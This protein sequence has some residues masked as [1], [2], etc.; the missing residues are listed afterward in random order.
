MRSQ[1]EKRWGRGWGVRF[2]PRTVVHV[3][4]D[5]FFAQVEALDNP[6]YR[7]RPLIVGGPRDSPR[8]VVATCS[9]E[10]RRFGV[11]SAM[12]I[13][14]AVRLCPH[15]VFVTPRM[16]R[17]REVSRHI[18]EILSSIS[19]LMEPLSVDE[20]FLD[21]TG[22]EP[23]YRDAL[24]LGAEIKRRIREGTGLTA[25]VGIAPNKFIA[26]LASDSGKPDG[27][28][29]IPEHEVDRFLLPL[30]VD[31]LWGVG[32]RT[33][34]RLREAGMHTV[35]DVRARPLS[36]LIAVLG[37]RVGRHVWNFAFGR[38]ERPVQARTEAK[39][40]G[41]ET[42][43][44]VDVPDGPQLRAH[45][46]RLVASVGE[47][48]RRRGLYPRTVTVKVRFPDFTTR[49]RSRTVAEG[50]RDDETLFRHA[51]ALL[52]GFRLRRP[53]RL[54]GVSVSQ[55]QGHVQVPLFPLEDD[56]TDPEPSP[57]Y[58]SGRTGER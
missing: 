15:A 35:A 29:A 28:V 22:R 8:G 44:P 48:M 40:L 39:S 18:R 51:S 56:P 9:Y 19:P 20:A 45:L 53:L 27:L 47:R 46:A 2:G 1:V 13:R 36:L 50:I 38:D 16:D 57:L 17:Y 21:M 7:G 52:D 11:R 41:K 12:P 55:F 23:C 42:T 3:D 25:S 34:A 43:F 10:A 5:A 26:K 49:T 30:P 4:M 58:G 33:A 6:Q 31:V 24:H 54:L 37:Q 14:Q 32:P